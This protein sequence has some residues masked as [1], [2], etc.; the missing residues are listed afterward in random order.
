MRLGQRLMPTTSATDF[1]VS[2][3]EWQRIKPL[4]PGTYL[5]P[6]SMKVGSRALETL[7]PTAPADTE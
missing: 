5:R 3:R 6:W 2:I 4:V 1:F 7:A